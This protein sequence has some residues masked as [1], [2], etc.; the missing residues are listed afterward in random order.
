[1]YWQFVK[2]NQ[3]TLQLYIFEEKVFSEK[4]SISIF[5][6]STLNRLVTLNLVSLDTRENWK[7]YWMWKRLLFA[8]SFLDKKKSSRFYELDWNGCVPLCQTL[9]WVKWAVSYEIHR[10]NS[11]SSGASSL[12]LASAQLLE[13]QWKKR[14]KNE[15][16]FLLSQLHPISPFYGIMIHVI[17]VINLHPIL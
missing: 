16:S 9:F 13:Q 15:V 7:V 2:W 10:N 5:F 17:V 14:K 3:S 8:F 4:I 6:V 1:M 11:H 12:L